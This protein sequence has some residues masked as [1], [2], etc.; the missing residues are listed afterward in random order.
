M[1]KHPY[2][3]EADTGIIEIKR[4]LECLLKN[5]YE[6]EGIED[7]IIRGRYSYPD[8]A[9]AHFTK[10]LSFSDTTGEWIPDNSIT[11]SIQFQKTADYTHFEKNKDEDNVYVGHPDDFISELIE[12]TQKKLRRKRR[13]RK[14]RSATIS[15]RAS[16]I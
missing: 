8:D 16:S 1:D 10:P 2:T 13:T 14:S 5:N 12:E 7:D 15:K 9:I 6:F 4:V 3:R 11:V